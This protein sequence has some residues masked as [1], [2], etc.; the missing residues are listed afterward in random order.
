MKTFRVDAKLRNNLLIR[1]REALGQSGPKAA[2]AIGVS[3]HML[4]LYEALKLSPWSKSGEWKKSAIRIA[5]AY[6]VLPEMLWPE[7]IGR[8]KQTKVSMEIDAPEAAF[9]ESPIATDAG[10][11]ALGRRADRSDW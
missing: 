8:V 6:R 5:T 7:E 3:Y 9:L 11:K 2:E 1:A 10:R 4:N